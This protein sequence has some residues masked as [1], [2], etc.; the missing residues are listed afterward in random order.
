[1]HVKHIPL[2]VWTLRKSVLRSESH[3]DILYAKYMKHPHYVLLMIGG[4][5]SIK[6]A[7]LFLSPHRYG[8]IQQCCQQ[9][10]GTMYSFCHE[11]H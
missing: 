5:R 2:V 6:I 3:F 1:M 7:P 9:N 11:I 8:F 4:Q 10:L